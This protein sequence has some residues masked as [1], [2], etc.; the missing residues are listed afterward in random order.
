M[1]IDAIEGF[2][3]RLESGDIFYA[4]G[5]VHPPGYVV[6]YPKYVVDLFGDRVNRYGVRYRK[7]SRLSEERE[8]ISSRYPSYLRYDEFYCR[9]VVVVPL[10]EIAYTYNPIDRAR[11]IIEL[12]MKDPVLADVKDMLIDIASATNVREI[13]V[14]GSIL[15]DLYREDSDIDIVVYGLENGYKVYE[16]LRDAVDR[17]PRYR[18]YR[19]R[20]VLQLYLRRSAETPISY[21]QA[22]Y[23]ESR[24][25][26]EGYFRD[27]EYF[28]RLV[29]F[30]WEE[31][32]YG[33]CRCR[34][35]G[36]TTV[37][38]RIT[39]ARESMFTPC[40]YKVEVEEYIEGVKADIVEVYSL[41]GRFAEIAQEDEV[42]VARGSVELVE[43]K[44]G[45]LYYR[46]YVGDERDYII[47][48]R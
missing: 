24:R 18:R 10:A 43:L 46:L 9:D 31:T 25:V 47:L 14:S 48:I 1:G 27:R 28:I 41:R 11:E 39:D 42:V 4:K 40:R 29:K 15:V 13:G 37:K 12:S 6:S 19:D 22:V 34:K 26:L 45:D 5:V 3:F 30:P 35:L 16:Y 23:Q 8:Y 33:S 44:S 36:K 21:D 20:D 38:L 2:F 32:T 7:L 17:D